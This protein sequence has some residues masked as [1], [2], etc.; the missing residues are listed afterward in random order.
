MKN[1]TWEAVYVRR[2]GASTIPSAGCRRLLLAWMGRASVHSGMIPP[3]RALYFAFVCLAGAALAAAD[4]ARPGVDW[5]SFRGIS[6]RG[7]AEGYPA[8]LRWNGE[9][10]ENV[11][12]KT[13]IPGLGHSRPVVWRNLVCV[14]TAVRRSRNRS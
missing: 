14:T 12:W 11:R 8:P 4:S 7:V 9:A 13:P 2:L 1:G 10:G 3:R 5:P 6:A